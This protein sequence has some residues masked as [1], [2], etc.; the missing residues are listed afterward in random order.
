MN[1]M[2]ND[3]EMKEI[4][5]DFCSESEEL[6]VELEQCLEI[7]EEDSV[8]SDM[9]ETFHPTKVLCRP[10]SLVHSTTVPSPELDD[11]RVEECCW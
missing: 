4:V 11:S 1:D 8:N 3:P 7:L 10:T 2:L 5:E 9:L 6:F